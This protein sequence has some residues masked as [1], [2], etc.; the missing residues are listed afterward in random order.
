VTRSP[1]GRL[2]LRLLG[3]FVAVAALA[4]ASF[5]GL[6]LWSAHGEVNDLVRRQ[7]ETTTQNTLGALADAYREAGTW[8]AADL[9]SAR[10][11]A[12][13]GGALLEVRAGSGALVLQAGRGIGPGPPSGLWPG[14][15]LAAT[16]GAPRVFPVEVAGE[17]VG[18]ASIR[19]PKGSLPPAERQL[20]SALTRTTAIGVAIAAAVALLVGL[21]VTHA[22][23]RPLRR[24]T[25]AVQRLGLGER[26]ARANLEAPGELGEL[27]AAVDTMAANL[28]RE[29]E[30]RRALTADVAHELR[31]PVTILSAHC[32]AILDGVTDATPEHIGSLY[33]EVQR[34]G[35]L[36]EDLETLASAEAAGLRLERRPVDLDAVVRTTVE[37]L[38]PRFEAAEVEL[39]L[40][41]EQGLVVSGDERRLGQ[42]VRNLLTN[43]LAATD[44]GGRV[45]VELAARDGAVRVAVS[46]TGVG[47]PADELPHVF[48][49]F[50]RGRGARTT[51]GSGIGL[52]V[53]D[54]LVRA[55][56]G[57][58]A[59]ASA[60]GQGARFTVELPR[61]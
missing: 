26:S 39:D 13:S 20:R 17:T 45:R 16:Y 53:V 22:I 29:D 47:I 34:L 30:L 25:H 8:A 37:L 4:I 33:E 15:R 28:E 23:T 56:G 58:V 31:T 18:R 24:L 14:A 49:R 21:V 51:S 42:V 57:T 46:D 55:H 19:Y 44:A 59:A 50:W 27:A 35:R 5:A 36:I 41:S 2:Q 60:P 54:E 52:A 40:R 38:G 12:V 43:A 10:A 11:V 6:I 61:A 3:A 32:E 9:R 7:Q 48:E 1:R